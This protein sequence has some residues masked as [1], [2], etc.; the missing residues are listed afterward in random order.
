MIKRKA[1]IVWE[2]GIRHGQGAITTESGA[3][4]RYS[5]NRNHSAKV[6]NPDELI[7]AAHATCFSMALANELAQGGFT[8]LRIH[9]TATVTIEELAAGWTTT[10]IEL[11]VEAQVHGAKQIDFIQAALSAKTNCPTSRLLNT[12]ISM[13]ARLIA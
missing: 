2:G 1:S 8:A 5:A 10:G 12:V 4:A 6:A 7:A 11:D 9:T 13:N 3:E